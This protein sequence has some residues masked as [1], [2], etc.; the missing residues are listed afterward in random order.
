MLAEWLKRPH[1]AEWWDSPASA[2]ELR[3]TYLPG[4]DDSGAKSY[5]AILD[6]LPIGFIQS[7]VAAE[8]GGD[9]WPEE[10]DPGVL[11]IDHFLADEHSLGRGLGT[12]MVIGF[13]TL[14]FQDA[15]VTRIQV[16]PAP[17]NLRAIRCYQRAGFHSIG[18]IVTPDGAALLMVIEPAA[19]QT[20]LT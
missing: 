18:E 10:R 1:V 13:V 8:A 2:A 17:S 5:L 6:G 19:L 4:T 7:Y 20:R 15:A 12:R 9:W 11:G 16:D 14:L 3:E